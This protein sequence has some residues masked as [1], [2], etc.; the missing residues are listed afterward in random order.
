MDEEKKLQ[1]NK[2]QDT[3]DLKTYWNKLSWS[4]KAV[5]G[6]NA[7]QKRCSKIWEDILMKY[8]LLG[9]DSRDKHMLDLCTGWGRIIFNVALT[10]RYWFKSYTGVDFSVKNALKFYDY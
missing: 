2:E 3:K 8:S 6:T 4:N 9:R 10:S 1:E 5:C 7:H